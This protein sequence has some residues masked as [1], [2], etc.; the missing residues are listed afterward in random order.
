MATGQSNGNL[1][2]SWKWLAGI[3]ISF[4][5]IAGTLGFTSAMQFSSTDSKCEINKER[6]SSI[7]K[8]FDRFEANL[9]KRFDKIEEMIK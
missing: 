6:I 4:L 5:I 3:L 1:Y 9:N 7:N 8:R 2:V